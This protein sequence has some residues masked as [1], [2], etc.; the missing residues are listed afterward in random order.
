MLRGSTFGV[1]ALVL[2]LA[3]PAAAAPPPLPKSSAPVRIDSS[4]GN[5]HFVSWQVEEFGLPTFRYALDEAVDPRAKQPEIYRPTDTTDAWPQVGN[6]P[7]HA[8][9]YN[10]GCLELWSQAR[11]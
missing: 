3:A 1:A 9:A 11:L 7:L 5:G 4:Y 10:H 8:N 2:C 6:N